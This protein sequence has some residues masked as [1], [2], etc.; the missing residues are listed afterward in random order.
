MAGRSDSSDEDRNPSQVTSDRVGANDVF[1]DWP[2]A[3]PDVAAVFERM[4]H[5]G[6]WGR[7]HGPHCDQLQSALADYHRVDHVRLCSSG[8]VGIELALRATGVTADDEVVLAAYDYKANFANVLTVGAIPVLIDTLPGLPVL[9]VGQLEAAITDRTKAVIVSHLHGSFGPVREVLAI[10]EH[11]GVAV[12]EDACQCPGA[13]L[14]GRRAGSI[15]HVGVLS[16]GGSKL[17]TAGRGGAILTRDPQL[18]QRIQLYT[19][20]GN[21]AYP[22]SEMQAAVLLPQ[23][24]KLD[25]R[26]RHRLNSV[27]ILLAEL[28]ENAA[29]QPALSPSAA[30]DLPA[31]YKVALRLTSGA[32]AGEDEAVWHAARDR[33]CM[34]ARNAGIALDAAFPALHKIHARRRF[35]S[36]GPLPH[37]TVLHTQLMTLHHPLL[38]QSESKVRSAARR[39]QTVTKEW[40]PAD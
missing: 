29:V 17:L 34:A 33:L 24:Q 19:Q 37:A 20:R 4:L 21:D 35:R 30:D 32:T 2:P 8:T 40:N 39:L 6:S 28:E 23:L 11:H 22:L 13:M 3:D 31:F 14:S 5:D 26:N 12:I 16:F 18:A 15:G 1:P 25:Q 9:D 38:L 10:A 27:R 36:V 7:Y